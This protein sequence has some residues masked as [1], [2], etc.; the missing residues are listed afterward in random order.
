MAAPPNDNIPDH[1]RPNFFSTRHPTAAH[2]RNLFAQDGVG[3]DV[4]LAS[5]DLQLPYQ[6][7]VLAGIS[8][9]QN[10]VTGIDFM[11]KEIEK[12][13]DSTKHI[14]GPKDFHLP[15]EGDRDGKFLA[16]ENEVLHEE[17]KFLAALT[18]M[19]YKDGKFVEW[20]HESDPCDLPSF[21]NNSKMSETFELL[22]NNWRSGIPQLIVE[23][24]IKVHIHD[25]EKTFKQRLRDWMMGQGYAWE[26]SDPDLISW[27][28]KDSPHRRYIEKQKKRKTLNTSLHDDLIGAQKLE[29]KSEEEELKQVIDHFHLKNVNPNI[30]QGFILDQ[31]LLQMKTN[32]FLELLKK[33]PP[34]NDQE[35]F[36][37]YKYLVLKCKPDFDYIFNYHFSENALEDDDFQSVSGGSMVSVDDIISPL[38]DEEEEEIEEE[39]EEELE[40]LEEQGEFEN[41]EEF[42][43]FQE[44]L[45][46]RRKDRKKALKKKEKELIKKLEINTPKKD[47]K[48]EDVKKTLSEIKKVVDTEKSKSTPS[49]PIKTPPSS[50]PTVDLLKHIGGTYTEPESSKKTPRVRKE[51]PKREDEPKGLFEEDEETPITSKKN[52]QTPFHTQGKKKIEPVDLFGTPE[53]TSPEQK[54]PPP[55]L[56]KQKDIQKKEPFEEIKKKVQEDKEKAKELATPENKGELGPP[57][58]IGHPPPPQIILPATP[59]SL[60]SKQEIDSFNNSMLQLKSPYK[61]GPTQVKIFGSPWKVFRMFPETMLAQEK[62][63]LLDN[64]TDFQFDT[65]N[66]GNIVKNDPDFF[67]LQEYI[68]YVKKIPVYASPIKNPPVKVPYFKSPEVTEMAKKLLDEND[69]FGKPVK[70]A[71]IELPPLGR[72]HL[73]NTRKSIKKAISHIKKEIGQNTEGDVQLIEELSLL[74]HYEKL[75]DKID[76]SKKKVN[77]E[78]EYDF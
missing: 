74:D 67:V 60:K 39:E 27:V 16:H 57:P 10:R 71:G 14:S 13:K 47:E 8:P 66:K 38:S 46:G 68:N 55:D 9:T 59:K 65:L 22:P 6:K 2:I 4:M 49:T 26:Y 77:L 70:V 1:L 33:T 56:K 3:N 69:T 7:E 52:L 62:Q 63:D 28:G 18:G 21:F 25:T 34:K 19:I 32:M 78:E 29:D 17:I 73:E 11:K 37:F 75:V 43:E 54:A 51:K 31:D 5:K 35:A 12:A 61:S 30:T 42:K 76:F 45:N 23:R 72:I 20:D 58:V 44:Y 24:L 50:A 48:W 15:W 53:K 40:E 41:T 36:L 64:L